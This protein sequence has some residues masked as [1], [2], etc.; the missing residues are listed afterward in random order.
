[1]KPLRSGVAWV[2]GWVWMAF[3]AAN[4]L[5]LVW[6]GSGH[7]ALVAA[8]ALLASCGGVFVLA[9]RPR[10]VAADDGVR[11]VN[12]LREVCVPWRRVTDVDVTD[13]LRIHAGEQVFRVWALREN[14]RG[15][16]RENLLR[17][18]G[19]PE[20]SGDPREMRPVNLLA[21]R[22]RDEVERRAAQAGA[23]PASDP[24]QGWSPAA[25]GAAVFPALAFLA[26]VLLV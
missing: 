5:D 2:L 4:L 3:A 1:M 6:R 10:V 9:L 18:G 21:H 14:R 11:I 26:A 17:A 24:S 13:V 16:V 8:L 23:Q 15:Q 25:V 22:L 19:E 20:N 12:P 7:S